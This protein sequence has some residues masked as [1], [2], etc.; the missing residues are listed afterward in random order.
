MWTFTYKTYFVMYLMLCGQHIF[1]RLSIMPML[2]SLQDR[3][4]HHCALIIFGWRFGNGA[5]DWRA[6]NAFRA[7]KTTTEKQNGVVGRSRDRL[8][9][10]LSTSHSSQPHLLWWRYLSVSQ[11]QNRSISQ[12]ALGRTRLKCLGHTFW[13]TRT[14]LASAHT[15]ADGE[16]SHM[17]DVMIHT[18]FHFITSKFCYA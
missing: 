11:S 13:I 17:N 8:H 3:R 14:G 2:V 18:H 5:A 9:I 7:V 12:W 16:C 10:R 1:L 15:R 6:N 4:M